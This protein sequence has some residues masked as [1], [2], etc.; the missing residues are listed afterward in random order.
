MSCLMSDLRLHRLAKEEIVAVA[1]L[2]WSAPSLIPA[3]HQRTQA[4]L[5]GAMVNGHGPR[6]GTCLGVVFPP[7]HAY[8]HGHLWKSEENANKAL[9]N[10]KSNLD[11]GFA[12]PFLS[13]ADERDQRL[14]CLIIGIHDVFVIVFFAYVADSRPMIRVG[15]IVFPVS[16]N[17]EE[18]SA[19]WSFWRNS[20]ILS[21]GLLEPATALPSSSMKVIEAV[22]EDTLPSTTSLTHTTNAA[23]R[24]CQLGAEAYGSLLRGILGQSMSAGTKPVCLVLDLNAHT[25]DL[26][27]AVL[28]ERFIGGLCLYYLGFHETASEALFLQVSNQRNF[29]SC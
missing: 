21:K 8:Q 22:G 4:A 25:G 19:T 11:Q 23:E 5:L 26:G 27:R 13:R 15:K 28:R 1:V 16:N 29:R 14:P 2:N 7:S 18:H 9:A 10:A 20:P 3:A 17:E 12:L 6:N 24:S